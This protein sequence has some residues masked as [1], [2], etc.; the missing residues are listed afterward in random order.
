VGRGTDKPFCQYGCPEFAGKFSYTFTPRSGPGS[1]KPPY[2]DKTCY[3]ELVTDRQTDDAALQN[4]RIQLT[5]LIKSWAAY[6]TKGKF[7][8]SFFTKLSGDTTL[9]EQ[10]KGNLPE[11]AIRKSWKSDLERFRKI[12]EKYL[13]YEDF[14]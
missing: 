12:R 2:E 5:W 3:G 1:K 10:L 11:A 4:S 9:Q 13:L 7:F 14:K 8:T 6:P